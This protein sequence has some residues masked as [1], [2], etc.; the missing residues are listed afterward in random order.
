MLWGLHDL[1]N[2]ALSRVDEA[3]SVMERFPGFAAGAF[4]SFPSDF[5]ADPFLPIPNFVSA[6]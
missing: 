1:V 5:G 6:K 3:I 2:P 4:F